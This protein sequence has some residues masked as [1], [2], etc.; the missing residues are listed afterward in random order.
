MKQDKDQETFTANDG[1]YVKVY[2]MLVEK[3]TFKRE[4]VSANYE[5][6]NFIN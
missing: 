4:N 5:A 3:I 6:V 1:S 2:I